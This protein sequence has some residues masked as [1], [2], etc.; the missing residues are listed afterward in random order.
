M[1]TTNDGPD[2]RLISSDQ[3]ASN[4]RELA[5]ADGIILAFYG[6]PNNGAFVVQGP[7]SMHLAL[8]EAL[9]RIADDIDR[10]VAAAR[11]ALALLDH[12]EH[13]DTRDVII[14]DKPCNCPRGD[15]RPPNCPIDWIMTQC[16]G[17]DGLCW[18]DPEAERAAMDTGTRFVPVCGGERAGQCALLAIQRM[19]TAK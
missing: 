10:D 4:A 13:C 19:R 6:G 7:T 5:K 16:R 1:T 9:R 8:P 2:P 3:I 14:K 18:Y 17:C 11:R 12:H 15:G